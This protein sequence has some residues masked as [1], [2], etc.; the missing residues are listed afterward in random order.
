MDENKLASLKIGET[1][2]V[3]KTIIITIQ[4][5]FE[6]QIH[7]YLNYR[8]FQRMLLQCTSH[9][10]HHLAGFIP[11]LKMFAYLTL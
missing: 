1:N 2:E 8:N 9:F 11:L 10:L 6:F 4:N 7:N 5:I 3:L